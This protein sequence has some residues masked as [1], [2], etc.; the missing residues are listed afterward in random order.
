VK[1]N[2]APD[3]IGIWGFSAGGHLA[4][5]TGTHFDAG[6][7]SAVDPIDR[8]SSRPDFMI[9]T[10]PV[11]STLGGTAEASFKNL[12]GEHASPEVVRSVSTDLQVSAQTPPTFL[13]HSTDDEIV[14]SENSV[15]FYLALVKAGVPAEIHIY[16]SEVMGTPWLR[17]MPILRIGQ[18]G[19]RTG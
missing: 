11:I 8:F 17:S 2:V 9:L 12:L 1:F 13:Q 6:N 4:S 14:S 5:L 19:W 10:Y 7:T 15:R 16:Q 18:S 3:R